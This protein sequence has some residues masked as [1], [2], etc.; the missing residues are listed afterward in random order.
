MSSLWAR[1][2]HVCRTTT[3][4]AELSLDAILRPSFILGGTT[5]SGATYHAKR[6]KYACEKCGTTF[7]R[8]DNLQ[9]HVRSVCSSS[10]SSSSSRRNTTVYTCKKCGRKFERRRDLTIH[11]RT[12]CADVTEPPAPKRSKR[13][14]TTPSHHPLVT[15]RR[16]L[17]TTRS[18]S[19]LRH[20]VDGTVRCRSCALVCY[21]DP[22]VKRSSPMQVRLQI[23]HARHDRPRTVFEDHV[24]GTDQCVQD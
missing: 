22:R 8:L 24:P 15:G 2:R 18:T 17:R 4:R 14:D 11:A 23:N 20:S 1:L 6:A 19:L 9:R 10:S 5:N 12:A 21:K 3:S 16:P 13:K 7:G